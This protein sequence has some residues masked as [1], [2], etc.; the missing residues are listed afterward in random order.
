MISFRRATTLDWPLLLEWRNDPETR[1]QSINTETIPVAEHIEWL[2]SRS[3]GGGDGCP[4]IAD[5][6]LEPIG[7][8]RRVGSELSWTIAPKYRGQGFGLAM[9]AEF[10]R[11]YPR[12]YT[13]TIKPDNGASLRIA[14]RCRIDVMLYEAES[15]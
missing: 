10:I 8:M 11:L 4:W 5:I 1:H 12:V 6:Y 13:A 7:T 14:K 15:A 2:R 3:E 9:V